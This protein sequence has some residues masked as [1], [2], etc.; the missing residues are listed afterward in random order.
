MTALNRNV[1]R[2]AQSPTAVSPF[3]VML[4][5]LPMA[6]SAHGY[7]GS[8]VALNQAGNL[9]PASADASLRVVGVL[10]DEADNSTGSAGD[11]SGKPVRGAYYMANSS[12]TDAITDSDLGRPCFVV[13][14]NTVARTS[15]LGVRPVAGR[16]LGVDDAGVLVEVGAGMDPQ[17]DCDMLVLANADLTAKQFHYVDLANNS[18]VA[19]AVACTAA[20]QRIVGVV[21]N[22]P[23]SG[24]VAVVR[25]LGC[26]R[27]S[28]LVAGGSITAGDSLGT[29]NDGRAKTAVAASVSS[30][31][32]V[33][34]NCGGIALS[35]TTT[36]GDLLTVLLT[37][38]GI[39]PT[40][41]A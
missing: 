29:K 9:V 8:M 6:A 41:A 36:N 40:T 34:S 23:A 18:G 22:A 33:G 16:I 24:A 20:G 21:Q 35:P 27:T 12:S 31:T 19:A 38:T 14:D 4:A 28:K 15:A 17:A 30:T 37:P 1:S 7:Q 26:G 25:P 11:V 10:E 13:D 32:T 3:V 39:S 5:L 2:P